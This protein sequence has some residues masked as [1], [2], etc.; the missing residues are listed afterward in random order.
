MP[1]TVYSSG[2]QYLC[3]SRVMLVLLLCMLEAAQKLPL[4]VTETTA[5]LLSE[6]RA[7]ANTHGMQ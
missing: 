1:M 6:Y 2:L 5:H 3:M 7:E 4:Q